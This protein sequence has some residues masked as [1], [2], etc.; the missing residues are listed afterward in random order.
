MNKK[1]YTAPSV[2]EVHIQNFSLLCASPED[3]LNL[4]WSGGR[5]GTAGP[6]EIDDEST[7]DS[8]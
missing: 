1:H 4:N 5:S 8:F 6:E 3:K 7:F 2:M